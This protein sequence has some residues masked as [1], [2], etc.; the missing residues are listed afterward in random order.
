MKSLFALLIKAIRYSILLIV[1]VLVYSQTIH[2]KTEG[3]NKKIISQ[4]SEAD[5]VRVVPSSGINYY[6][7]LD[8]EKSSDLIF[9]IK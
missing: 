5:I 1:P 6:S 7:E 4:Q 3:D 8:E 2:L 9:A